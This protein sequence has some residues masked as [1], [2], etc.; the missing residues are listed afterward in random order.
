MSDGLLDEYL[1]LLKDETNPGP[2]LVKFYTQVTDA[3]YDQSLIP[4]LNKLCKIYGKRNVTLCIAQLA[5]FDNLDISNII[6]LITYLVK[7]KYEKTLGNEP[8][9]LTDYLNEVGKEIK[10]SAR[11]V[12]KGTL[13]IGDPFGD[14]GTIHDLEDVHMLGVSDNTDY[15]V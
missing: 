8:I 3:P 10:Q 12:K 2:I 11:I 7:Q 14:F 13:L 5:E 9:H 4:R 6:R 15:D 1:E